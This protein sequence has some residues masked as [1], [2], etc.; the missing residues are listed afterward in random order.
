MFSKKSRRKSFQFVFIFLL[1]TGW[2][3]SGWPQI[4]FVHF[5]PKTQEAHAAPPSVRVIGDFKA[6]AQA[7]TVDP[8]ASHVTNDVELL[9]VE[10]A[11][12]IPVTLS[13]AAGFA[14]VTGAEAGIG[15]AGGTAA[16]SITV[17]WRRWNGTDGSPTVA[18]SGNHQLGRILSFQDVIASGDPWDV[19]AT[20]TQSS[21]ASG[22]IPAVTTTVND[23]M[24]VMGYTGSLPDANSTN[25]FSAQ[26]NAGLASVTEQTD[27]T[28]NSGNGGALGVTTGTLAS[29][30]NTG[31]TTYDSAETTEKANV[32][33]ALKPVASATTFTQNDFEWFAASSTVSL[34]DPWPS[35]SLDLAELAD[36][37]AIPAQNNPPGVGEEIRL[38][39]NLTIGDV[40]LDASAQAF[41]LQ[42][43]AGTDEDCSTGSWTDVGL[44]ASTT[45][46][47]R[48][49]DDATLGD[50]V[51]EVN[52]ITTSDVAQLYSEVNPNGTNPNSATI[53][54]DIEYD[55]PI[56][57]V[58][59]QVADATTYAFRMVKSGGTPIL[60]T[61]GDCPT[62]ETEPGTSNLMRHGNF[63]IDGLEKGLFWVN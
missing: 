44:K 14:L 11:N 6:S 61:A 7:I 30:G 48:L 60:Y 41:T 15:T 12:Q 36:L 53:G 37:R 49:Y 52:Q 33:I 22:T 46:A 24:I 4:P 45:V 13:T 42:Y 10:T 34:D 55:W 62:L 25:E 2:I 27:N 9:F 20:S 40:N 51:T 16:T 58:S 50:S 26:E 63:F 19:V 21:T 5:P 23:T 8:N 39:I 47:W 43:K 1:I 28:K 18:D 31:T 57:S 35:G 59:G 17:F 56:E 38:Q 3:F 32:S 29:F 54:Q